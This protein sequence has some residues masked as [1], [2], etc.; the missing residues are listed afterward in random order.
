VF[1]YI[2]PERSRPRAPCVLRVGSAEDGAL[3]SRVHSM[4]KCLLCLSRARRGPRYTRSRLRAHQDSHPCSAPPE[5]SGRIG[6]VSRHSRSLVTACGVASLSTRAWYRPIFAT[7]HCASSARPADRAAASALVPSP[8]LRTAGVEPRPLHIVSPN[9]RAVSL[10]AIARVSV[11]SGAMR[12]V[13]PEAAHHCNSQN[14]GLEACAP[15]AWA[16]LVWAPALLA[17]GFRARA[18]KRSMGVF[19]RPR[20]RTKPA[21]ARRECAP[22][23]EA[24]PAPHPSRPQWTWVRVLQAQPPARQWPAGSRN[25]AADIAQEGNGNFLLLVCGKPLPVL[26]AAGKER[27]FWL[28]GRG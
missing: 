3:L 26:S 5:R 19:S 7:S 18:D 9:P 20:P 11:L 8:R 28:S 10:R 23:R 16:A 4:T 12:R 1:V 24:R 25:A 2:A 17:A 6:H 27:A 15:A 21:R 13:I 22:R 14:L